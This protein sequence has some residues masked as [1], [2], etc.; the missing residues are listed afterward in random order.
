MNSTIP[1][2]LLSRF[3]NLHYIP[4]SG[5]GDAVVIQRVQQ[6]LGADCIPWKIR[7][8]R[9]WDLRHFGQRWIEV[10]VVV[11]SSVP[12]LRREWERLNSWSTGPK[13]RSGAGAAAAARDGAFRM[14]D[15]FCP[16]WTETPGPGALTGTSGTEPDRDH[17]PACGA[18]EATGGV[19]E[20]TGAAASGGGVQMQLAPEAPDAHPA[21]T[22]PATVRTPEVRAR[23][24][25]AELA[26]TVREDLRRI[27][28]HQGVSPVY[29]ED[30]IRRTEALLPEGER[31]QRERWIQDLTAQMK[32]DIKLPGAYAFGGRVRR[33][34]L[35][36][37]TG[38][39]KTTTLAKIA[40]QLYQMGAGF[41]LLTA[42]TYRVGAVRQL[43]EYA[44][45]MGVPLEVCYSA[46]E[47][48]AAVRRHKDRDVLLL[49]TPGRSPRHPDVAG[50]MPHLL[51]RFLADEVA[52]VVC[53][54]TKDDDLD[55]TAAA[56]GELPLTSMIAT[57]AD[58]TASL[59]S[60]YNLARKHRIPLTYLGT[61]QSVPDDLEVA[62][63]RRLVQS[64]LCE[65]GEANGSSR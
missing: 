39:G 62:T 58:E 61:G 48:A 25:A 37:P 54:T 50:Q 30:L 59:A 6:E 10:K 43:A 60:I 36:G 29:V 8:Y 19:P 12:Q 65:G 18:P 15:L 20:P 21:E 14:E 28:L 44:E 41:A 17:Q 24:L 23:A 46:D 56:Y 11:P 40:G 2:S 55:L 27:L 22:A 35:V 31:W 53:C 49:D 52:L 38:V 33:L 4:D 7:R 26:E 34:A 42:D 63:I 1:E 32:G 13:P 9:R 3:S 64:I 57:K 5:E 47:L 45:I 16:P 51:N